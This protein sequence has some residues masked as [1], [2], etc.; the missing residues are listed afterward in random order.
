M[1]GSGLGRTALRTSRRDHQRREC[2]SRARKFGGPETADE[3]RTQESSVIDT[4]YV[5][6]PCLVGPTWQV[7]SCA[8]E[9]WN[10]FSRSRRK[11]RWLRL[12][13]AAQEP[14]GLRRYS[15]RTPMPRQTLSIVAPHHWYTRP[16][17]GNGESFESSTGIICA[18]SARPQ[19]RC[20][21]A[22]LSFL[23]RKDHSRP[24][25]HHA[26][27]DSDPSLSSNAGNPGLN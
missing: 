17:G 14:S 20:G 9:F 15:L 19:R 16:A 18:P 6:S 3:G 7:R 23:F 2:G 5:W 12:K 24:P 8:V 27:L 1:S 25:E 21:S 11:L 10:S 4:R 13:E 22:W 26:V